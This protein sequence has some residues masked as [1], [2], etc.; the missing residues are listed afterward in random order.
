M[1]HTIES[2]DSLQTRTESP[3][4]GQSWIRALLVVG[5]LVTTL[6]KSANA[7]PGTIGLRE[8][9]ALSSDGR[10]VVTLVDFSGKPA[11]IVAEKDFSKFARGLDIAEVARGMGASPEETRSDLFSRLAGLPQQDTDAAP[12]SRTILIVGKCGPSRKYYTLEPDTSGASRWALWSP[13]QTNMMDRW[14]KPAP[15]AF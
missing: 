5:N 3:D 7:Q 14:F 10:D 1:S 8:D 2:P 4:L 9:W 11:L 12:E 13:P 6:Q 15:S